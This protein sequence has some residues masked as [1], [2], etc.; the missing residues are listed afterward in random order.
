MTMARPEAADGGSRNRGRNRRT[1]TL[2]RVGNDTM[3]IEVTASAPSPTVAMSTPPARSDLHPANELIVSAVL[4][5]RI[6]RCSANALLAWSALMLIALTAPL[7]GPPLER[8]LRLP[9]YAAIPAAVLVVIA[10]ALWPFGTLFSRATARGGVRYGAIEDHPTPLE[11]ALAAQCAA[12]L[13]FGGSATATWSWVELRE[14]FDRAGI[15]TPRTIADWYLRDELRRIPLTAHLIE[16]EP[17]RSS[18]YG[19]GG[20]VSIL[21]VLG[22]FGATHLLAGN[23]FVVTVIAAIVLITMLGTPRLRDRIGPLLPG[24]DRTLVGPGWV[25]TTRGQTWTIDD[26]LMIVHAGAAVEVILTGPDGV[27]AIP[28]NDVRDPS[29]IRLWQ[30]WNHPAPRPELVRA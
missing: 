17:I 24:G 19:L 26:A 20:F 30:A 5:R 25:R 14:R 22:V 2:L 13:S 16:P 27:R 29:F 28:F 18:R 8:A 3:N 10:A 23:W 4:P 11:K 7:W 1:S 6:F 15:A 12:H 9:E 21:V